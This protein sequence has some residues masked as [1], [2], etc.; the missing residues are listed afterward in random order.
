MSC[1]YCLILMPQSTFLFFP[2]HNMVEERFFF[3]SQ[4]YNLYHNFYDI[5]IPHIN[6]FFQMNEGYK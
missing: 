1:S 4:F 2:L 3:L 5:Q 6:N